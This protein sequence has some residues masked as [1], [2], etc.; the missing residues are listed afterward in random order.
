MQFSL[1]KPFPTPY[2]AAIL[3]FMTTM[4]YSHYLLH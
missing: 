4:F 2:Q 1:T 3:C